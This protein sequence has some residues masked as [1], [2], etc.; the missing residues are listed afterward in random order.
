MIIHNS[1]AIK[2]PGYDT[3]AVRTKNQEQAKEE[4]EGRHWREGN[5]RSYATA[6]QH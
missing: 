1:Y 4:G 5:V 2:L 6:G 3:S